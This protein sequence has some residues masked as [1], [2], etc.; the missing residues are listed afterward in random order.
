MEFTKT[1]I[2]IGLEKPF[3]V[4]HLSDTH[5]TYADDRDDQ[6]KL[7]L[8]A[9]RHKT[10]GPTED[11]LA[12]AVAYAKQNS[13]PIIHTGDLIDFVSWLNIDKAR[14]FCTENDVF[15]AA[16]NHEFSLYVGEA[17]EDAD[18]RNQSLEKVQ[19]AFTNDIRFAVREIGGVN[20][21]A[22]DNGYYL[23][24]P[25]Q[26][27]KLKAVA[28]LGKPIVLMMH[29]PVYTRALYDTMMS[30]KADNAAIMGTPE[31]LMQNYTE[32]RYRQQKPD[33]PTL[34]AFEYIKSEPLI[35]ALIV[36][37]LHFNFEDPVT[38]TLTQYC[39]GVNC[40]REITFD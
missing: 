20:F 23:F 6:R 27:E 5:L 10:F 13:L 26:L 30:R 32:Y 1:T 8:A 25:W 11:R 28:A 7:D 31:E 34:E 2:H 29:T 9:A 37:H 14:E 18:Y 38:D 15:T 39:T 16:G 17:F 40:A 33:A 4:L 19:S 21:I 12:E 35:K 22:V 24:E 36:G 3:K